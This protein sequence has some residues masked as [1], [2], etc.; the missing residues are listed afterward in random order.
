MSICGKWRG[1]RDKE[2]KVI[3]DE[4]QGEAGGGVNLKS[5][6]L[7]LGFVSELGGR[8]VEGASEGYHGRGASLSEG[9]KAEPPAKSNRR[10]GRRVQPASHH[11]T[12]RFRPSILTLI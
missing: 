1:Q 9:V 10:L 12:S 5:P 2:P 11:R 3:S 8:E 4:G 6:V 7:C